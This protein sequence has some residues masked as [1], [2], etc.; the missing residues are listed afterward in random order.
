LSITQDL[1]LT[2]PGSPAD[3]AQK[4]RRRFFTRFSVAGLTKMFSPEAYRARLAK[5]YGRLLGAET[6]NQPVGVPAPV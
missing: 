4:R 3:V 6:L 5:L 2:V 1:S